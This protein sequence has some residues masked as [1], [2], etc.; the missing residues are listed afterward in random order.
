MS[1]YTKRFVH[2]SAT[3]SCQTRQQ[4]E[5]SIFNFNS[6]FHEKKEKQLQHI[7]Q[8]SDREKIDRNAGRV[9]YMR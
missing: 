4:Q 7:S 3:A 2:L 6:A 9:R 8:K 1:N 5:N